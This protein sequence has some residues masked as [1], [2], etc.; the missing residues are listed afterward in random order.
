MEDG[1]LRMIRVRVEKMPDAVDT[2][3]SSLA[4]CYGLAEENIYIEEMTE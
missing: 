2:L 1:E 4:L 3:V